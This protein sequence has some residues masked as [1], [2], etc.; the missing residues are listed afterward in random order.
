MVLNEVYDELVRLNEVKIPE[1]A[2]NR[3][4]DYI[5]QTIGKIRSAQDYCSKALVL[6]DQKLTETKK[7]YLASQILSKQY[8][9]ESLKDRRYADQIKSFPERKH[10][11]ELEAAQKFQAQEREALVTSFT[12]LK[13]AIESTL[14]NL[15]AAK[16]QLNMVLSLVKMEFKDANAGAMWNN[17]QPKLNYGQDDD[18]LSDLALDVEEA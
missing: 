1:D 2:N 7:A 10:I 9:Y 3:G 14:S 4:L 16:E 5:V 6:C 17:P 18:P 15:R 8:I 11:L 13:H 12:D